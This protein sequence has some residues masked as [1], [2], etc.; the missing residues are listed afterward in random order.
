M[1]KEYHKPMLFAECFTM[2]EHIAA[3][4][5]VD[6]NWGSG[7]GPVGFNDNTTNTCYY[8]LNNGD[9]KVFAPNTACGTP[10]IGDNWND[11]D[12]MCYDAFQDGTVHMFGS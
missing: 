12:L 11:T 6:P 9:W 8:G 1:R 4:C 2:M 5:K 10:S 3:N 7:N